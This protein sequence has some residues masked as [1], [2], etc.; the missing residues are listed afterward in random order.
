MNPL[1]TIIMPVYNCENYVEESI[2]SILSQTY[3]N[4]ELIIVNDDS[5]DRTLELINKNK[6][7]RIHIINLKKHIGL[8]KA[9]MEGYKIAKGEYVLRQDGDD[10][11]ANNRLELQREYLD[12]NPKVGIISCLISC[13]TNEPLF[14]KDCVFIE[15]IQN[16]CTEFE[17]IKSAILGGF[18]P[19]IFPT[20]MIRKSLLDEVIYDIKDLRFDDHI[21]LLLKLIELSEVKKLNTVLYHYRRYKEAYHVANDTEYQKYITALLKS[22]DVKNHLRFREFYADIKASAIQKLAI[23]E[24]SQTRVLMLIDALNIG[25]T[26]THV[27]NLTKKL[28]EMGIYVV[29]V[30]SGG[31]MKEIAELYGIKVIH[32]PI[33]GDYISNKKKFGLIKKLKSIVDSEKINIIHCHLFASMQLASELY[34]MYNIPYVVTVHGLFYPNDI[35]YSSCLKAST[36]LAVS[37]PVKKML[38]IK[39][40]NR[41]EKKIVVVPNGIGPDFIKESDTAIDIRKEL[42]IPNNTIILSYCSRL[43]WNKTDAARAFLFSF[44]QLVQEVKNVQAIIIGDGP[45]KESL[46][47]EAQ[48]INQM[49]NKKVVHLVGSK[50]NITPYFLRSSVIIGTGRVALEAMMCRKPVIAIGNHGYTGLINENNKDMQWQMYFGDHDSLEKPNVSKLLK[51]L[52]F[53]VWDLA[54]RTRI[55]NWGRMWCEQMFNNEKIT[56]DIVNIYKKVL[57]VHE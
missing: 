8:T 19:I 56:K 40:G 31:P 33:E 11:S 48:I 34:R 2:N 54:S 47:K 53:I 38:N 50:A 6:D 3:T 16:H 35:L 4:W 49:V 57:V 55:G 36:V 21:E 52:R 24:N 1:I 25:G 26:E 29:I 13:F 28:I 39:L 32:L 41:I 37:E 12:K 23:N 42:N 20:L 18:M 44:S 9:F 51:D 22:T 30:S 10:L 43:D 5:N 7:S 17:D 45:G 14:R 46:D 27:I 15:R